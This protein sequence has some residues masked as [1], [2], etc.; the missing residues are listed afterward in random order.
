[1]V[2]ESRG[3][4]LKTAQAATVCLSGGVLPRFFESNTKQHF[5]SVSRHAPKCKLLRRSCLPHSLI[6]FKNQKFDHQPQKKRLR[7]RLDV[8][9]VKNYEKVV[10]PIFLPHNVWGR[11][12]KPFLPT[13]FSEKKRPLFA[14]P[15]FQKNHFFRSFLPHNV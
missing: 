12:A 7:L 4:V 6:T 9:C 8:M 1:M 2:R 15:F 14:C 10:F 13:F 5:G 11:P 3:V